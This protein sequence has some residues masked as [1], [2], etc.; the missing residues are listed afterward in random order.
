MT[1]W[2][3]ER[4][5]VFEQIHFRSVRAQFVELMAETAGPSCKWIISKR[6]GSIFQ[7]TKGEAYRASW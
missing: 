7:Y 3:E 5:A 1:G 6:D 4:K 2:R